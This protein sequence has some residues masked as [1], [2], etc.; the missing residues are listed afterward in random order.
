MLMPENRFKRALAAREFQ[1][2]VF[3]GLIDPYCAEIMAGTGFDWLMIDGEHGANDPRSVLA[4]LQA[5]APYPVSAVVRTVDHDAARIKQYLDVGVQSLLVPM[6]ESAEQASALVR[7]MRYP[8]EGIRG[9]GTAL[10]RAARWNG[11]E[12]YFTRADEEMCL[13]VQVESRAGLAA[14]DDILAVKGVDGVFIG[15]SDLAASLGHLGNPGHPEV[16]TAVADAL[17]RIVAAGRAAG[18]FSADPAAVQAYREAGAGFIAVGVDTLLLRNAAVQ[19]AQRFKTAG[20]PR[21]GAAY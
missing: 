19:L 3:L 10:A 21:A 12:G 20:T 4:Q 18:V 14:L 6:V 16:K 15:P 9:V 17:A 5:V 13:I 8:P 7:A 11:V 1:V 2:G